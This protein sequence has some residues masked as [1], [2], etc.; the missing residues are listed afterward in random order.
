MIRSCT[1]TSCCCPTQAARQSTMRSTSPRTTPPVLLRT[2]SPSRTVQ[3]RGAHDRRRISWPRRAT[4]RARAAPLASPPSSGT[5]CSSL[6]HTAGTASAASSR[7]TPPT[8]SS[9]TRGRH[10]VR[11][12]G[13]IQNKIIIIIAAAWSI[14]SGSRRILVRPPDSG[15]PDEPGC[16]RAVLLSPWQFPCVVFVH[17][18]T[19]LL[20]L[21]FFCVAEGSF[22]RK[23]S[24]YQRPGSEDINVNYVPRQTAF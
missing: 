2:T 20:L 18:L 10:R 12:T 24:R 3:I 9:R 22:R 23:T 8:R 17:A 19:R 1:S 13:I 6:A 14:R 21:C 4:T 15:A 5:R 16:S 7:R 11:R